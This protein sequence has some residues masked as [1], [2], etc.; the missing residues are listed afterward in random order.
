MTII[1]FKELSAKELKDL[2]LNKEDL[3]PT[4]RTVLDSAD[5]CVFNGQFIN[6]YKNGIRI[7][8]FGFSYWNDEEY[9]GNDGI[10]HVEEGYEL[11]G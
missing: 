11:I 2:T 6:V 8:E 9:F 7:Y 10:I 1:T 3:S 4:G 5:T